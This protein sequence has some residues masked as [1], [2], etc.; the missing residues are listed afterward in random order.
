MTAFLHIKL[1]MIELG[2]TQDASEKRKDIEGILDK[3][4]VDLVKTNILPPSMRIHRQRW[5]ANHASV[6]NEILERLKSHTTAVEDLDPL[7][8]RRGVSILCHQ[9]FDGTSPT[10]GRIAMRCLCNIMLFSEPCRQWFVDEGYPREA[11]ERMKVDELITAE[12]RPDIFRWTTAKT[13]CSARGYFFSAP[14]TRTST[15]IRCSR[16]RA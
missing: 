4:E 6:R 7:L 13:S 16:K 14:T 2:L 10:T 11:V 1:R 8:T 5:L 9:G 12:T 3:L 15:S